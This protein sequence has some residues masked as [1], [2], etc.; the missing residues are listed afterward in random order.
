M[1]LCVHAQ[2]QTHQASVHVCTRKW[3]GF[4]CAVHTTLT[5]FLLIKHTQSHTSCFIWNV[6]FSSWFDAWHTERER[7]NGFGEMKTAQLNQAVIFCMNFTKLGQ[8]RM[9]GEMHTLSLNYSTKF[10][11]A[12]RSRLIPPLIILGWSS[13]GKAF[14]LSRAA[15][16]ASACWETIWD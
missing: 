11:S 2:A 1:P 8:V 14:S 7:E 12:S 15:P 4:I 3:T 13:C 9:K 6:I 5:Q 10:D 16:N